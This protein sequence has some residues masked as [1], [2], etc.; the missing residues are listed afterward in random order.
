MRTVEQLP[1][2]KLGGGL[3]ANHFE[4]SD[5]LRRKRVL[6]VE[7]PV[8]LGLFGE[9]NRLNRSYALMYIVQQL[10]LVAKFLARRFEK[11]QCPADVRFRLENRT[12]VQ[13]LDGSRS[14]PA[15]S[16]PFHARHANLYAHMAESARHDLFRALDGLWNLRAGRVRIAIG[17]LAALAAEQLVHGHSG[18]AALDIPERHV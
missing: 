6:H 17:R 14:T 16:V 18:L 2:R 7:Q 4:V 5:V 15:S 9:P 12:F 11:L 8:F 13:A 10:D 1:H 3:L